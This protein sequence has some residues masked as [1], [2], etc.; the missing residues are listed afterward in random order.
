MKEMP[1]KSRFEHW[2]TV[3]SQVSTGQRFSVSSELTSQEAEALSW[4][5]QHHHQLQC[6]WSEGHTQSGHK[7][8]S[9]AGFCIQ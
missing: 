1:E 2:F 9:G 7:R 3:K 4:P 6:P 8:V 5:S